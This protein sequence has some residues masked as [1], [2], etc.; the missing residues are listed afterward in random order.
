MHRPDSLILQLEVI[1]TNLKEAIASCE[2]LSK[3]VYAI[4]R[5][6]DYVEYTTDFEK[7]NFIA[8]DP[9]MQEVLKTLKAIKW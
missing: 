1:K 2:R 6:V 3:G 8:I 7:E 9:A 4:Q 5:N